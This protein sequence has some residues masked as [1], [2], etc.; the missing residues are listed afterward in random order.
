MGEKGVGA[1]RQEERFGRKR[2]FNFLAAFGR[3]AILWG[4]KRTGLCRGGARCTLIPGLYEENQR[5]K[6][7]ERRKKVKKGGSG[8]RE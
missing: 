8:T 3:V 6:G 5:E 4:K 1:V 7:G 2:S